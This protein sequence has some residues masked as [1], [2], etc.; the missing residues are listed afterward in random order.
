M[1]V[2]DW[3]WQYL[4]D[5]PIQLCGNIQPHGVLFVLEEPDF[6]I[7]QLSNNA[8]SI[9]G[10]NA[11]EILGENLIKLLGS[12]QINTIEK[13][14]KN[15]TVNYQNFIKLRLLKEREEVLMDGIIHRNVDNLLILELEPYS[16]LNQQNDYLSYYH[17]VKAST[18]KLE[19]ALNLQ[20]L[21]DLAVQEVR[22]FTGFD[23]VMIY[24]FDRHFSYPFARKTATL[25]A[26][27]LPSLF[28]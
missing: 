19:T 22:K 18:Y 6:K 24:K 20:A 15:D 5:K 23:R 11:Q 17:L 4:F 7:L 16:A 28:T 9:L 12:S 21:C 10:I 1:E 26:D 2:R 8:E 25:G 27:F 13:L 3:D 14:I